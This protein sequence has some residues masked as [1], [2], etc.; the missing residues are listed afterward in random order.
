MLLAVNC[1]YVRIKDIRVRLYDYSIYIYIY[2]LELTENPSTAIPS[3]Q[4]SWEIG[5]SLGLGLHNS[6]T[7]LEFRDGSNN[8]LDFAMKLSHEYGYT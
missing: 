3:P 7:A 4:L 2:T 1:E 6:D 5:A 8:A